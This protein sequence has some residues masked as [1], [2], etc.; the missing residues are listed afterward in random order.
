M[1]PTIL[2]WLE[3]DFAEVDYYQLLGRERFDPHF[4]DVGQ[5]IRRFNRELLAYQNH[6]D[7]EVAKVAVELQRQLARAADTFQDGDKLWAHHE[8]ILQR[9][10]HHLHI[11]WEEPNQ[12]DDGEGKHENP[13]V[14]TQ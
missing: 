13:L 5:Q 4:H 11:E 14:P 9:I 7:P 1:G 2:Q 6:A 8:G 10:S 3:R 12:Q